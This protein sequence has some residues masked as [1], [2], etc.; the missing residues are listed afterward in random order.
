MAL[1]NRIGAA[2]ATL[3][4]GECNPVLRT[5]RER[6]DTVRTALGTSLPPHARA[7]I[8]GTL[9]R[10]DLVR[11]QVAALEAA[12]EQAC[13]AVLGDGMPDRAGGMI[14]QLAALRGIGVQSTAI[15]VREAFVRAFA[16]P[17]TGLRPLR[18]PT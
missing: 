13:D 16:W 17:Q 2:L 18:L 15:L 6:L 14:Q 9:G 11:A 7:R 5:R 8:S 3:G 12:L 10:L 1:A 4:A